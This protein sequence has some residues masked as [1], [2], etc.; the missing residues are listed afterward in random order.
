M[1]WPNLSSF[2]C[3]FLSSN[4]SECTLTKIFILNT[5]LI[6]KKGDSIDFLLLHFFC[7]NFEIKKMIYCCFLHP[8]LSSPAKLRES[9]EWRTF[10]QTGDDC[11]VDFLCKLK[12][13]PN[14]LTIFF[15]Y[16]KFSLFSP[17]PR[18]NISVYNCSF[19]QSVSQ[20]WAS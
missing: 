17:I 12:K 9:Q 5:W 13:K 18:V 10:S 4:K 7:V 1:L 11:L 8:S 3:F 2:F 15:R 20:N 19:L 14:I 6:N 16:R